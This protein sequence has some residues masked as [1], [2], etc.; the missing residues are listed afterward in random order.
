[1][2]YK[3][4]IFV[5]LIFL[6]LVFTSSA[7]ANLLVNGGAEEAST[8]GWEVSNTNVIGSVTVGTQGVGNLY[9][10]SGNRLF[11]FDL[12]AAS[13]A[14][15]WQTGTDGLDG[16]ALSL[17]GCISTA[18]RAGDD[19]GVATL[20]I[21]DDLGLPLDSTQSEYLTSPSL[22]WEP[23]SLSLAVPTGAASWEVRLSG[24]LVY[25]SYI[26]VFYDDISLVTA[27]EPATLIMLATGG[28][29]LRKKIDNASKTSDQNRRSFF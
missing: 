13:Y 11:A 15:M 26:N 17:S 14:Q 25:G 12:K 19:Y 5:L 1:M 24:T 20:T 10:H 21:F 3:T 18:D 23:W 6:V 16:P 28:L 29:L 7:L 8:A 9:P 27:P 2:K 22:V 4:A